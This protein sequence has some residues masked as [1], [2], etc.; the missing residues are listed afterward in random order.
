MSSDLSV[1]TVTTDGNV[2]TIGPGT[3]MITV[4]SVQDTTKSDTLN[5]TVTNFPGPYFVKPDAFPNGDGHSWND[6]IGLTR[7]LDM[8]N[9]VNRTRVSDVFIA[10]GVYKPTAICN[11]N[12]SFLLNN[13]NVLGGFDPASSG[14]DTTNRNYILH[15]TIFSGEI[16]IPGETMDNSYHVVKTRGKVTIDGVT[17]RDGRANCRMYGEDILYQ[18]SENQ[19]GGIYMESPDLNLISDLLLSHC[20]VTNNSAFN[21]AGGIYGDYSYNNRPHNLKLENCLIDN[22]LI[23]QNIPTDSGMIIIYVNGFGAGV[24]FSGDTLNLYDCKIFNNSTPMG[25]SSALM[26]SGSCTANVEYSSIFNNASP[27]SD[28]CSR[29]LATLNLNNSTLKGRLMFYGVHATGNITNSTIEGGYNPGPEQIYLTIDNSIWTGVTLAELQDWTGGTNESLQVKYSIVGHELVGESLATILSD[30]IPDHANWLDTLAYNGSTTQTFRLKNTPTNPAKTHG[31]PAYLG[32]TDQRGITR[33]DTV[34]IGAYQWVWPSQVIIS[35]DHANMAPGGSLPFSVSVLPIWADDKT[36][37]SAVSDTTNLEILGNTILAQS[38]GNARVIV[39][40]HDGNRS[41]TCFVMVM[42][43]SVGVNGTVHNG[44]STCY[45]AL[46][47]IT[48]AGNGT[49]F[50]LQSGGNTEMI[51][52]EKIL[53]LPGTTV[54]TGAFLH[55]YIAPQGPW[56]QRFKAVSKVSATEGTSSEDEQARSAENGF[57]VYP[58]PTGGIFTIELSADADKTP[59]T[60]RCYN[61]TGSLIMH[62]E[63][64][65]GRKLKMTLDGRES[66]IYVVRVTGSKYSGY[67]K[68]IKTN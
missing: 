38:E 66:G 12:K 30:S 34:S 44:N 37:S 19:G 18:D 42:V 14:S 23:Q 48:V 29:G 41:D 13:L 28:I 51:A 6:A 2:L 60:V 11:R 15:E 32:F 63:I 56:C 65:S 27:F 17:I 57:R 55:G 43:D 62:E 31:N 46:D 50:L 39:R 61:M 9:Q 68:L 16:G 24:S 3:C 52:G 4:K 59:V 10:G 47:V 22:N 49:S 53:C 40:T 20:R 1:A 5:L 33:S 36:W 26:I 35:P 58:N 25:M 67:K 21:S 45:S 54:K 7:L 64:V 8:L